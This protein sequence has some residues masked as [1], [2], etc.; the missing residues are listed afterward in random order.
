[1]PSDNK[2]DDKPN[3]Q[4]RIDSNR[5]QLQ[6]EQNRTTANWTEP[7]QNPK[8]REPKKQK[9]KRNEI[10]Q[11]EF[12]FALSSFRLCNSAKQLLLI[13]CKQLVQAG[14]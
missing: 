4:N 11:N 10:M 7:N 13:P 6:K 5:F 14:N 8:R 12:A 9:P 1:M 2:I 3:Q